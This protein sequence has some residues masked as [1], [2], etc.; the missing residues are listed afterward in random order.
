MNRETT[1]DSAGA[2]AIPSREQL[3]ALVDMFYDRIQ[4]HPDLGPVF[5]AA[6]RDWPEHKQL[7]TSFWCSVVLRAGTYR[8]NPMSAHRPHAITTRHFVQWLALWRETADDVLA[9]KQAELV[10]EYANRIGRSLRYGLGLPEPGQEQIPM[11]PRP[12]LRQI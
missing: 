12:S 10:L 8:G 9:P 6:V 11:C 7:L 2:A 3:A 5:N 4:V 1:N